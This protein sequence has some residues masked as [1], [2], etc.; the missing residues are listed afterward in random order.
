M[1]VQEPVDGAHQF[2]LEFGREQAIK[3]VL[4]GGVFGELDGIIHVEPEVKRLVVCR[5]GRIGRGGNPLEET[6]VAKTWFQAHV[7][8]HEVDYFVPVS[9]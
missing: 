5:R 2:D 8:K 4:D 7:D 6:G 9:R 3:A 1:G